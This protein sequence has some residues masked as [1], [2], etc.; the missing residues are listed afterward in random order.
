MLGLD[1]LQ[2]SGRVFAGIT[3]EATFPVPVLCPRHVG[4][5]LRTNIYTTTNMEVRILIY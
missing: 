1:V 5:D 2:H 4:S 3:T